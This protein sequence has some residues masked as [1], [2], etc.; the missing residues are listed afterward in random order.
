LPYPT[1]D[2]AQILGQSTNRTDVEALPTGDTIFFSFGLHMGGISMF[3]YLQHIGP[4]NIDAG[5]NA[6]KAHDTS[7]GPL[8]NQRSPIFEGGTFNFFCDK[9]H[10]VD[11]EFIGTVLELTFSSR[12]ADRTVQR[13]VDQ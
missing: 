11:P 7:I 4:R 9:F 10:M 6:T 3:C 2:G 5:L 8:T 12:I 1:F 13:V